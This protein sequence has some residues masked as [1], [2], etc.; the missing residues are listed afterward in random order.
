MGMGT[1]RNRVGLIRHRG[2]APGDTIII[3]A[4]L[5]QENWLAAPVHGE[6]AHL[7]E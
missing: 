2:I 6:N 7:D 1:K 4:G 3:T 5:V